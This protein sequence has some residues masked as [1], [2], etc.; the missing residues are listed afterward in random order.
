MTKN[1]EQQ[2]L[3]VIDALEEPRLA[4]R[5]RVDDHTHIADSFYGLLETAC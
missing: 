3:K 5:T 4:E 2:P 1:L